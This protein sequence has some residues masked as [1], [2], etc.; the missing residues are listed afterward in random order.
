LAFGYAVTNGREDVH[1]EDAKG[2]KKNEPNQETHF[3]SF[4]PWRFVGRGSGSGS[5][6]RLPAWPSAAP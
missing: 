4:A 6:L 5:A 2:A 1:R 3:A